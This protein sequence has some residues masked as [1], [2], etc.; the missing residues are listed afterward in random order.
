MVDSPR[1]R[2]AIREGKWRCPYCSVVNRGADLTCT[3]CGATRD[4]DVQFFLEEAADEVTDE[5]LLAT[6]RAGAD[7]LCQFCQT[8]NRP[9]LA[10]SR[11]FGAEPARSPPH[12]G[13]RVPP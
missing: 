3:G 4:K 8:S 10:H 2:M 7:W 11:D 1:R 13:P 6:A 12:P 9:G 5:Q